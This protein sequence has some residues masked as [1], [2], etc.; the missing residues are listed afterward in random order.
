MPGS[1]QI[2]VKD[3]AGCY[4]LDTVSINS[5]PGP[6]HI[7]TT[8]TAS[9]CNQASGRIIIDSIQSGTAGFSFQLNGNAV[10]TNITGLP[11]NTY[12]LT[13][14]DSAGCTLTDSIKIVQFQP[15]DSI[16]L[17]LDNNQ[18]GQKTGGITI[19][20]VSGG[21]KPFSY[22]MDNVNFTS[23]TA[24]VNLNAGLKYFYVKDKNGCVFTDSVSLNFKTYPFL[25]LPTDT[26]LCN[27]ST[28]VLDVTQNAASYIWQDGSTDSKITISKPGTYTVIVS[29][30]GCT[31]KDTCQVSYQST[32]IISLGGNIL[33]CI[34]DTLRWNISFPNATYL[35]QD[36]NTLPIYYAIKAGNYSYRVTNYCGS[37]TG[38]INVT[39]Q[40]CL[41][42]VEIPNVFSPNGDGINDELK[43]IF[44]CTPS[45]YHLI[46]FDRNGQPIFDTKDPYEPWKGLFN[47]KKVP[48]GTYYYIL[49]IKGASD[50]LTREKSGGIT[51][52]R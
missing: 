44:T 24:F 50:P 1:Y 49:T 5:I 3:Q 15:A 51:I 27:Q 8:I 30:N 13:V 37:S 32:P 48:L 22:S 41:C 29:V 47:G 31:S 9:A 7:Y 17:V 35:W 28:L 11:V 36:Q 25:Q 26:I 2:K 34:E 18:C 43:P 33:K 14:K 42:N 21:S 20:K 45:I 23:D 40:N 46:I 16:V 52:I 4:F 38:L 10:S 39:T 6:Q 19:A 12:A